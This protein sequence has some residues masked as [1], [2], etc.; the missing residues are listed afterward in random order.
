MGESNYDLMTG[1]NSEFFPSTNVSFFSFRILINNTRCTTNSNANLFPRC[2]ATFII[3]SDCNIMF[4]LCNYWNFPGWNF[5]VCNYPPPLLDVNY[6][7]IIIPRLT[8][9]CES[10]CSCCEKK[11]SCYT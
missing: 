6:M 8:N 5:H 7:V 9:R 11:E 3:T 10:G 4:I 1:F 2:S